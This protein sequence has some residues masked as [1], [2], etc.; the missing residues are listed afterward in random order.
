MHTCMHT[1]VAQALHLGACGFSA[2]LTVGRCLIEEQAA[3]LH[4]ALRCTTSLLGSP[5]AG[6]A[7]CARATVCM[8]AYLYRLIQS[9]TTGDHRRER[10][11]WDV[12][13]ICMHEMCM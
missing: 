7:G 6:A 12:Y 9:D 3:L 2:G 1:G 10:Y 5:Y 11:A 8:Y 13:E 4:G